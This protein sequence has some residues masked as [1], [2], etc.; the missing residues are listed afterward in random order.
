MVVKASYYAE[1]HCL[2][3]TRMQRRDSDSSSIGV[4]NSGRVVGLS[5]GIARVSGLHR[6][7]SGELVCLGSGVKGIALNLE[8]AVVRIVVLGVESSANQ[9][10]LVN[11]SGALVDVPTGVQML[12]CC[13]DSLGAPIDGTRTCH[14]HAP[15]SAI[16]LNAP[17]I[18]ER[19]PVGEP[20]HSGV[21][22]VDSLMP[23]GLGQ[24]ELIIGDRQTGKT[25]IALDS[26][27]MQ[28]QGS[29]RPVYCVYCAIGQKRSTVAQV[30]QLLS[31][32]EA[33]GYTSLVA[34]TASDPA[35]LQFLAPYSGCAMGEYYRDHGMNCLIIYDDLSKQ[36][37]AYRQMALLLRRPPAREAFPGDVFYLHARLLERAAKRSD[38]TGGGSLT[39]FP[40][41]ETQAGDFSAY[42]PTNVISITDGQICLDT[43]LFYRGY[44]P[45]I[46][47]GLSV[48]RVG[49]AAQVPAMKQVCGALKLELAQYRELAAFA[50]LGSDLDAATQAI[51]NRGSRLSEVL[52]QPPL[53]PLSIAQQLVILYAAVNG[54]LDRMEVDLISTFER[55]A[56]HRLSSERFNPEWLAGFNV[57]AKGNLDSI[58]TEIASS[59]SISEQT[60]ARIP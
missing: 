39:A 59:I 21:K 2:L 19:Q 29:G 38:Q 58:C 18:I 34:A 9:Y 40:I 48:S 12:G 13:L 31:E 30:V 46:N 60:K 6:V 32:K 25:A 8:P 23:L 51:I 28:S 14:S 27:L 52:K 37:V 11:R 53:A 5:D 3:K 36:A 54:F 4:A 44:R 16:E 56:I 35:P 24:R 20:M 57:E 7:K 15:R 41:I 22:A 43:E 50:Q 47:V 42:I 33:M 1:L 17:G 55:A 45:A 49:S 26:I 10:D